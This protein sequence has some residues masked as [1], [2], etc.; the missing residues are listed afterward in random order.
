[1]DHAQ[2]LMQS[3]SR[4]LP[5]AGMTI[6][7]PKITTSG[8]VA[9]TAEA[10]APSETGIVSSYVNLTV[11]KY[12]GLQRYSLEILERSSPEFFAAMLRQHDTCL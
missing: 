6:S 1:L 3:V 11:K 4:A 10:A 12:A 8:T 9:E 2:L 5:A 7:V